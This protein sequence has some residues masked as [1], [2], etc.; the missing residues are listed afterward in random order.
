MHKIITLCPKDYFPIFR[1]KA[2]ENP[3]RN[4][5][6]IIL[7]GRLGVSFS[8]HDGRYHRRRR[9]RRYGRR[10]RRRTRRNFAKIG[11]H[12]RSAFFFPSATTATKRTARTRRRRFST[13][14]GC[15]IACV[16]GR[17]RPA[18]EAAAYL[19]L[20]TRRERPAG[21]VENR[22]TRRSMR[23]TGNFARSRRRS[24]NCSGA[25]RV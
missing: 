4:N 15:F 24:F 19:I 6:R 7:G 9:C 14:V 12:A 2:F 5:A 20:R 13:F 23:T 1:W 8:P 21:G 11:T 17:H 16:S 25:I 3:L 18:Q 10:E 22:I